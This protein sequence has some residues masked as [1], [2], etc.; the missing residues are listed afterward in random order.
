MQL[1]EHCLV[2]ATVVDSATPRCRPVR[3]RLSALLTAPI[4]PD[5]ADHHLSERGE[6][7]RPEITTLPR[8]CPDD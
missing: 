6:T 3:I 8:C 2:I 1:I 5:A 7:A 4:R